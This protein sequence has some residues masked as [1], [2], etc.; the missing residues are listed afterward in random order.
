MAQLV[1]MSPKRQ[2]AACSNF[3]ME[4]KLGKHTLMQEL[5]QKL[6]RVMLKILS[7]V[8]TPGILVAWL[9]WLYFIWSNLT[10]RINTEA[11]LL[12]HS[13]QLLSHAISSVFLLLSPSKHQRKYS[14]QNTEILKGKFLITTNQLTGLQILWVCWD[15]QLTA[16]P[17]IGCAPVVS[18]ANSQPEVSNMGVC[19]ILAPV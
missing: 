17:A 11:T 13:F 15:W 18:R 6:D 19:R 4:I 14:N 10:K 8:V 12:S 1:I 16:R 7:H 3:Q 2:E 9:W 5:L